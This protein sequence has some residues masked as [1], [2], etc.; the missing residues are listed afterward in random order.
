M[1]MKVRT[2][3][4]FFDFIFIWLLTG[5]KCLTYVHRC[6]SLFQL[7]EATLLETNVVEEFVV[8]DEQVGISRN[9]IFYY[10]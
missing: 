5:S 2:F 6:C 3:L 4:L 9:F 7:A 10:C 1:F 8:G